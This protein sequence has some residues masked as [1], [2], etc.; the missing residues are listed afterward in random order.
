MGSFNSMITQVRRAQDEAHANHLKEQNQRAYLQSVLSNLS[1]GVLSFDP[2]K[3][4]QT[5]NSRASAILK[6]E[7]DQYTRQDLPRLCEE[8]TY[9][10]GFC[11]HLVEVMDSGRTGQTEIS[12]DTEQGKQLLMV[13]TSTLSLDDQIANGW[14]VVFDDVTNLVTAERDAAWGEVARRLAH[15]IK[16]PLTPIG[17][18]AERIRRKYLDALPE[19]ERGALDRSTRTIAE[20]VQTLKRMVDGFASY[21]RSERLDLRDVDLNHLIED[22]VELHR[23]PEN[24]IRFTLR[25]DP[26]LAPMSLDQDGIRQILNNI[27]VNA[28]DAQRECSDA[29]IAIETRAEV[30]HEQMG[31]GLIFQ[32]NGPGFEEH[33][34]G[35]VFEPYITSKEE[36]TGLGMAIVKRITQAHGGF[37]IVSNPQPGGGQ[38]KVWLPRSSSERETTEHTRDRQT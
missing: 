13:R 35:Q 7:L 27:I 23:Q 2:G 12:L 31:V 4:L 20:Q 33:I 21:A 25:L 5:H 30:Q 24:P 11:D 19:S 15:E 29:S 38:V 1:S 14:V 32:D 36:G 9:L 8:H 37:V 26:D 34:I 18:S 10:K 6:V 17:L 3:T 16:N 22:V 28:C